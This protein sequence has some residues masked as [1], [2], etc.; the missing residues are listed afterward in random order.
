MKKKRLFVLLSLLLVIA[1]IVVLSSTVF[2]LKTVVVN[3]YDYYDNMVDDITKNQYFNSTEKIDDVIESGEFKYGGNIF[4]LKKDTYKKNLE[5]NNP[6]IKII[7]INV[8][9]PNRM[10]VKAIERREYYSVLNNSGTYF[11]CDSEFKV[12]RTVD[13]KPLGLVEVVAEDGKTIFDYNNTT[14]N[15]SSG[16]FV[17]FKDNTKVLLTLADE[18]YSCH[19]EREKMLS[20]FSSMTIKNEYCSNQEIGKVD[21]IIIKTI[22]GVEIEIENINNNFADKILKSLE[23]YNQINY[24][25][26][27]NTSKGVIK[28]LDNLSG[29]WTE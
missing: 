23:I 29:S 12:L 16:D 6:Y 19:Y 11:V 7:S 26:P 27:E 3:F 8:E 13:T 5:K 1:V 4:L 18:M 10:V 14:D 25:N 9:F 21:S 22:A 20:F 2:T 24:E 15:L 28:V 17:E